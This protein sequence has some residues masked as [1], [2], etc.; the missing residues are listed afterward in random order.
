MTADCMMSKIIWPVYLVLLQSRKMW[1]SLQIWEVFDNDHPYLTSCG[2]GTWSVNAVLL[3]DNLKWNW[4]HSI[5]YVK[6]LQHFICQVSITSFS[7]ICSCLCRDEKMIKVSACSF[8]VNP[9]SAMIASLGF[10]ILG[11]EIR[12]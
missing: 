11:L 10:Q 7:L 5:K 2:R 8:I 3:E 12:Y 4:C 9:W 1:L 6:E